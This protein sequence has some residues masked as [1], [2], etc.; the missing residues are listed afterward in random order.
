MNLSENMRQSQQ[1]GF[2]LLELLCA[3]SI[4]MLAITATG[5]LLGQFM[6][7]QKTIDERLVL[8]TGASHLLETGRM[9][10]N[11]TMQE[12]EQGRVDIAGRWFN[13]SKQRIALVGSD[14]KIVVIRCVS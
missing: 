12:L 10:H 14:Q 2:L 11:I 3:V 4:F 5:G 7:Y 8:L 13:M 6:R 9:P 1:F